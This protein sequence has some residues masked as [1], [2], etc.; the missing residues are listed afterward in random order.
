MKTLAQTIEHNLYRAY[1]KSSVSEI[2]QERDGKNQ[3]F[4]LL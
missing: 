2:V 1:E 3:Y 4:Y